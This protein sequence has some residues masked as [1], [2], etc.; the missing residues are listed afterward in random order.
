KHHRVGIYPSPS[1]RR[2]HLVLL[3]GADARR[4]ECAKLAHS[5]RVTVYP[6]SAERHLMSR[7][8]IAVTVLAAHRELGSRNPDHLRTVSRVNAHLLKGCNVRRRRGI[9]VS[10]VS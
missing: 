2:R 7:F 4:A 5:Y 8:R 6:E 3:P 1:G 10:K 9:A